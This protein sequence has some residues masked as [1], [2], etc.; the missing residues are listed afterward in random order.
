MRI[1]S[2]L[3]CTILIWIALLWFEEYK[4]PG[5]SSYYVQIPLCIWFL[6]NAFVGVSPYQQKEIHFV[7]GKLFRV[8][9]AGFYF[10]PF[11]WV[12]GVIY[13][14]P[15]QKVNPAPNGVNF[16]QSKPVLK[17]T[18]K[19]WEGITREFFIPFLLRKGFW[20]VFVSCL[21]G[22][23]LGF[24]S[25]K[26]KNLYLYNIQND[27]DPIHSFFSRKDKKTDQQSQSYFD[28]KKQNQESISDANSKKQDNSDININQN[29]QNQSKK[30]EAWYPTDSFD[31]NIQYDCSLIEYENLFACKKVDKND[32][33]D[34]VRIQGYFI[35]GYL[36]GTKI[37]KVYVDG[38]RE[39][40][41]LKF[42]SF[43]NVVI[44]ELHYK[45]GVIYK[46]VVWSLEKYIN[47]IKTEVNYESYKDVIFT[48]KQEFK[49]KISWVITDAALASPEDAD[50]IYTPRIN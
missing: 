32:L 42:T 22:S 9:N 18:I 16:D 24:Y 47:I 45:N 14:D 50:K 8:L 27:F 23:L 36:H 26:Y 21:L 11:L 6:M 4:S 37:P 12:W 2:S 31:E 5:P 49:N 13:Q 25:V 7:W 48:P 10:Y 19:L 34:S 41:H 39:S 35:Q 44:N 30:N 20:A 15:T 28:Y 38:Y 43:F 40:D 46:N 33:D 17:R 1:L 29:Y 3:F